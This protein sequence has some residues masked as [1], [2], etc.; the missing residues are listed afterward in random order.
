MNQISEKLSGTVGI[1]TAKSG[2]V[3]QTENLLTAG[4]T[5]IRHPVRL[6]FPVPGYGH[7]L[8]NDFARLPKH[9]RVADAD[10]LLADVVLIVERGA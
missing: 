5:D 8:G 10:I 2:F 4:R 9:D 7:H 1:E 6:A 3:F